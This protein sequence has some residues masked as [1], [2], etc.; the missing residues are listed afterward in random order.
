MLHYNNYYY[1]LH[2]SS[3]INVESSHPHMAS[4]RAETGKP[5][6]SEQ[7][8]LNTKLRTLKRPTFDPFEKS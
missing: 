4:G 3:T 6:V 7:K 8:S 2:I 5:L 1:Y